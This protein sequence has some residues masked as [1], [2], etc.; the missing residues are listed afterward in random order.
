MD[1]VKAVSDGQE[2]PDQPGQPDQ[3]VQPEEQDQPIQ[4]AQTPMMNSNQSP[5]PPQKVGIGKRISNFWNSGNRGKLTILGVTGLIFFC[6]CIGAPLANRGNTP[7]APTVDVNAISTNAMASAQA[8]LTQTALAIPTNTSTPE[9]TATP[10]N[11]PTPLPSPTS[12]PEPIVLTGSG[13]SIVDVGKSSDYPAIMHAKYSSGSNFIVTSYDA[14][15]QQM[16]L[17]INV[18]GAYEGTVPVDFRESE[19]TSRLEIKAAG[20]WEIQILPLIQ[21]RRATIP[22]TIEGTGD[23]VIALD[24]DNADTMIANASL[25]SSNF[26]VY[27]YSTSGSIDLVFN[28]IAPYTGTALLDPDTF[29]ISVNATGPW[30][31]EITT[32]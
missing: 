2:Q 21:V 12:P 25:G 20:P 13:D 24:G 31:L 10:E 27:S 23:D 30:S 6:C 11:T 4:Q 22:G 9:N 8:P 3:Q 19:Y 17:L 18:I 7:A 5:Q 15:N 26:V 29:I 32:R 14:N 28:E 16:E 1:E